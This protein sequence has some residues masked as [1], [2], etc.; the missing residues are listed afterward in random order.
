MLVRPHPSQR[1]SGR[2]T[3]QYAYVLLT[4]VGMYFPKSMG[5][6]LHF[7]SDEDAFFGDLEGRQ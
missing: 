6:G 5:P 3:V 2:T 1:G 4:Y 7:L